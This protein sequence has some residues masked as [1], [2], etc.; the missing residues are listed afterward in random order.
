MS[1]TVCNKS[2][3]LLHYI[4]LLALPVV[5][6]IDFIVINGNDLRSV[7]DIPIVKPGISLYRRS[8]YRG[9]AP[10]ILL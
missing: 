2:F 7:N 5:S 3:N 1:K 10:Y 8:L 6:V 9:S 4:E